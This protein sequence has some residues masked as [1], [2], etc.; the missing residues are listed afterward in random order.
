MQNWLLCFAGTAIDLQQNLNAVFC[1]ND[2]DVGAKAQEP[3]IT[4]QKYPSGRFYPT[5]AGPIN[6]RQA[7]IFLVRATHTALWA[8]SGEPA[9]AYITNTKD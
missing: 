3:M 4:L 5:A 8:V 7:I 9:P 2:P 1:S 6:R